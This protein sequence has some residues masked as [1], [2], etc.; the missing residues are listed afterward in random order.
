[1]NH[2][3]CKAYVAHFFNKLFHDNFYC[4]HSGLAANAGLIE[5]DFL[6]AMPLAEI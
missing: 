4:C 5:R 3:I 2:V 1:M 6:F